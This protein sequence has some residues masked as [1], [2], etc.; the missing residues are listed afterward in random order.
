VPTLGLTCAVCEVEILLSEDPETRMDE[1]RTFVAAHD[2][3]T[4]YTS[5]GGRH[6][7]AEIHEDEAG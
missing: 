7:R 5:F 1:I 2:H 4:R 3:D 6:L